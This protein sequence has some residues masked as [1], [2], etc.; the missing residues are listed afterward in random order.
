MKRNSLA[1]CLSLMVWPLWALRWRNS[2]LLAK[3][4][5]C[6]AASTSKLLAGLKNPL[7]SGGHF[8]VVADRACSGA[9]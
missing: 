5:V 2:R 7:R 9:A 1:V 6:A 4:K 3:P 8:C